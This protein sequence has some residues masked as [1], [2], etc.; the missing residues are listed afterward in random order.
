[1]DYRNRQKTCIFVSPVNAYQGSFIAQEAVKRQGG[2]KDLYF[3]KKFIHSHPF[4]CLCDEPFKGE[5]IVQETKSMHRFNKL[6][7]F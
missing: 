7:S 6:G 5:S 1:M 3:K 2:L 4:H